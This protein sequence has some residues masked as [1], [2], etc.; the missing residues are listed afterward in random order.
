M[1]EL[2]SLLKKYAEGTIT[3]EEQSQLEQLTHRDRVVSAAGQQAVAIHRRRVVRIGTVASI[4]VVLA[5]GATFLFRPNVQEADH[6]AVLMAKTDTRSTISTVEE[7]QMQEEVQTPVSQ[8]KQPVL[9][10]ID[11]AEVPPAEQKVMV[12]TVVSAELQDEVM[13]AVVISSDPVV[14]CNTQCSP[15]SVINDIWK[16]L[17]V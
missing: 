13:P 2:E 8:Q 15:D 5:V 16:F 7:P 12:E 3:Q 6:E 14:A 17:K 11:V 4:A 9:T 10:T 1:K